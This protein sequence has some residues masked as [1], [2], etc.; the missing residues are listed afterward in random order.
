[1]DINY[2]P[3]RTPTISEATKRMAES[4]HLFPIHVICDKRG[5]KAGDH[6]GVTFITLV[7]SVPARGDRII[8][9]DDRTVEV[10][11]VYHT[12]S[13]VKDKTTGE[14]STALTPNVLA[15]LVDDV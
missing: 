8:L 11:R 1:M 12:V 6:T 13:E 3:D 4:L 14:T 7:S 2:D 9:Q 10:E 15:Y 5:A